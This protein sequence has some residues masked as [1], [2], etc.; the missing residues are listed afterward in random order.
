MTTLTEKLDDG[1]VELR[2]EAKESYKQFQRSWYEFALAITKMHE[3]ESWRALDFNTFKDYCLADFSDISYSSITKFV[4]IIKSGVGSSIG[5]RIKKK[6]DYVLPSYEACYLLTVSEDVLPKSDVPKI[7]KGVMDRDISVKELKE[8][9]RENKAPAETVEIEAETVDTNRCVRLALNGIYAIRDNID[10]VLEAD[11]TEEMSELYGI[12][13]DLQ[14]KFQ[15][16]STVVGNEDDDVVLVDS[17][18]DDE[19]IMEG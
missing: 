11:P 3:T 19:H 7:R 14:E 18:E 9:I 12:I 15:Q 17:D 16:L 10:E 2:A 5:T 13:Y 4:K 6:K 8:T 1:I